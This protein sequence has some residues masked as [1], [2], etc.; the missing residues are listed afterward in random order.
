LAYSFGKPVPKWIKNEREKPKTPGRGI[1][2][3]E[4]LAAGFKLVQE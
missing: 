1:G 3:S 2:E 4:A